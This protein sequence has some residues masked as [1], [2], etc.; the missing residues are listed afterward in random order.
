MTIFKKTTN[1]Y[2]VTDALWSSLVKLKAGNRCEKCGKTTNLNSHHVFTKRIASLRWNEY[3]GVCLCAGCH[4]LSSKFSAHLTPT[5]FTMWI[6]KRRGEEWYNMLLMG[7][8]Q[9]GKPDE[10]LT[11]MYLKEKIKNTTRDDIEKKGI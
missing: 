8:N 5:E 7:K 6:I 3:N 9:I 1:K 11:R 10:K 2:K 4:T